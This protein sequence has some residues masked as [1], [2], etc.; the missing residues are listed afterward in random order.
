MKLFYKFILTIAGTLCLNGCIGETE[1][2]CPYTDSGQVTFVIGTDS[3]LDIGVNSRGSDNPS[4]KITD[5]R[6]V[7]ANEHG[8]ILNPHYQ[9]L[10][11]DFSRLTIEGLKYGEYTIAFLAT[12]GDDKADTDQPA[13]LHDIWLQNGSDTSPIDAPY[14]YKKVNFTIT[15]EQKPVSQQIVLEHCVGKID[16]RVR[17]SSEYQWRFIKDVRIT[18]DNNGD[19]PTAISADGQYSGTG[20]IQAYDITGNLAFFSFPSETPLS[21]FVEIT[22]DRSDGET[23][24]YRYRF[25][26]CK[27]EAGRISHIDIDYRHPESDEGMMYVRESDFCKFRTD[28]MFMADEPQSVFYDASKRSFYADAPLQLSISDDH[29]LRVRFFSPVAIRD[30][31]IMCRFGK[32]SPE[33]L[34]LAHFDVIYPF[35]EGDFPIPA[36]ERDAVFTTSSG[37]KIRI[38]AQPNLSADEVTLIAE[39]DDPYMR[40][41]AQI[42][43]HWYI[44]FSPYGADNGHAYWRHMNPLLCRHGVALATNMAFMF[45]SEE[46]NTEMEKYDGLLLDNSRNPIDL[47]TLR[48]KI[49]SH[50][51]L[52]LGRV[53]G[54]GGLGGGTTYGLADY[55]YTG[56]YFD[57]TPPGSNPHNYPRQAMFHEYGHC[58]G[59]SHSSTM[60]YGD[61]WTVLCA[62]VFVNMGQ[63]GKLPVNS[64]TE[65]TGLPM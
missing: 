30:V 32:I 14:L 26:D 18:F 19:I 3:G 13:S 17:V 53:S 56:V 57:A 27:I 28:T 54:V 64:I 34:E 47:N 41:I 36:V 51:G 50:G 11:P 21:G 16:L 55:C 24:S 23:F 20:R 58:L 15:K 63:S 59:Y 5:L 43:S 2:D 40:K 29:R 9:K 35:M 42:D 49:R 65:V 46:F 38:P 25:A 33:F 52:V 22:S 62:T 31:R 39:T 37:R 12:T 48:S 60:T 4:D 45:S 10:E 7:I 1:P 44:R 6:Y 8:E 61:R